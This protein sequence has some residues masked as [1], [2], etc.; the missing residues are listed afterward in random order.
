MTDQV[1]GTQV[2]NVSHLLHY[3]QG[4]RIRFKKHLKSGSHLPA[5]GRAGVEGRFVGEFMLFLGGSSREDED[6][7]PASTVT[8]GLTAVRSW[9]ST[10]VQSMIERKGSTL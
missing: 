6:I 4:S 3:L 5:T 8:R 1:D 2:D 9:W 10:T 7:F